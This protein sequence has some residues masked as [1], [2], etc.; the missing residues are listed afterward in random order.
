DHPLPI[1]EEQT[2]SQPYMV[3]LMT[4]TL[5]LTDGERVLEVGTGSGYLAAILAEQCAYVCSVELSERL[6]TR[7]RATLHALGYHNVTVHLG[8]GT[9]GWEAEAP[10][11]AIVVGAAAPCL[12]RPLLAQLRLGGRLVVPMGEEDL[13]T[14]VRV[15]KEP[16]GFREEYFGECRF[17][18]LHGAYGWENYRSP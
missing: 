8:D 3:A 4:E 10:F 9:L 18:K 7:A 12:P 17:V 2:I 13:Q 5:K 16:A 11:D 15:W 6:A 14:L 1:G